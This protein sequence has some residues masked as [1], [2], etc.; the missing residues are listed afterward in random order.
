MTYKATERLCL[1]T[2]RTAIVSC[3]SPAAH[4]VLANPGQEV[5]DEDCEKYGLNQPV[6]T[7]DKP[8]KKAV[9]DAPQNKAVSMPH[10]TKQA[11]RG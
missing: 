11:K 9:E 4:F 6:P 1:N 5:S 7:T 8:G 10:A 3:D 2:E